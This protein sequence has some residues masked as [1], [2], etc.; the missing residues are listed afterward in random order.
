MKDD[1]LLEYIKIP[2]DER[3]FAICEALARNYDPKFLSELSKIDLFFIQ[4]F[5]NIVEVSKQ[6]KSMTLTLCPTTF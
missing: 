1:E 2:N 3:V 4:K 6:L 5:K